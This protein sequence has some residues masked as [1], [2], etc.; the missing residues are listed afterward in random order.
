MPWSPPEA[1]RLGHQPLRGGVHGMA[2]A[3]AGA[4]GNGEG[5]CGSEDMFDAWNMFF[6]M[7]FFI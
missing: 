5:L 1:L 4:S 3:A 2:H 7:F 6:T